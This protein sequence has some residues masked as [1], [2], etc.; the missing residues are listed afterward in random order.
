MTTSWMQLFQNI[1][2]MMWVVLA[3]SGFAFGVIFTLLYYWSL[4]QYVFA[5][6]THFKRSIFVLTFLRLAAF[7]G[8]LWWVAYP[9]GNVV[10]I[11]GFFIAFMLGRSVTFKV[12]KRKLKNGQS[13]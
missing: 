6:P 1:S 9:D 7:F 8:V 11:L 4:K 3:L 13:L 2:P 10:K 12:S 5:K